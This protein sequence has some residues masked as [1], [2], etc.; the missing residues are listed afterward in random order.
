MKGWYFGPQR[1]KKVIKFIDLHISTD[2]NTSIPPSEQITI[3]PGLTTNGDPTD[4]INETVPYEEISI[5]DDW[6]I[7]TLYSSDVIDY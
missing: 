3:Q 4:N 2:T 6:G 5:D 1:E 7:I